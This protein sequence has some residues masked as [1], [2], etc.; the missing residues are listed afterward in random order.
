MLPLAPIFPLFWCAQQVPLIGIGQAEMQST[1]IAHASRRAKN[2]AG[3]TGREI[4]SAQNDEQDHASSASLRLH[5]P[6]A[7]RSA[8]TSN[9]SCGHESCGGDERRRVSRA[10]V[11]VAPRRLRKARAKVEKS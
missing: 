9:R 7:A 2:I 8:R 6:L 11:R 1:G 5:G 3:K 4:M 10:S